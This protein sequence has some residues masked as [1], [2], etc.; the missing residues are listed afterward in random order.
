MHR[1]VSEYLLRRWKNIN[2]MC[3]Q[4]EGQSDISERHHS[5]RTPAVLNEDNINNFDSFMI[6]DTCNN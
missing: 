2:V 1:I 4:R 3:L 6:Q 5:G